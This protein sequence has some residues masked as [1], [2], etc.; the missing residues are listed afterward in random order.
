M[1]FCDLIAVFCHLFNCFYFIDFSNFQKRRGSI[2]NGSEERSPTD[3]AKF[4]NGSKQA[5]KTTINLQVHAKVNNINI[6]PI[7]IIGNNNQ[8][9]APHV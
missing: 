1:L 7:T 9:I 2:V 4:R 3:T 5:P 6:S 8:V